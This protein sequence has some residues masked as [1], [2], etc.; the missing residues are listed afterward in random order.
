MKMRELERYGM[1]K[2][3]VPL[4]GQPIPEKPLTWGKIAEMIFGIIGLTVMGIGVL[5]LLTRIIAGL[6][7]ISIFPDQ[8]G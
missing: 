7:N 1:K 8:A 3:H 2:P 4:E 5:L 6:L